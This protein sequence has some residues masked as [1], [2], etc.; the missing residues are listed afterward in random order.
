M[1]VFR[2]LLGSRQDP[3]PVLVAAGARP[4]WMSD[5]MAVRISEG[6]ENLEVVGESFYQEALWR[7][8]GGGSPHEPVRIEV[9]AVLVAET[10]NP[11]DANA[12]SIW[13]GGLKVGHL[14]RNEAERLRPGL[15][16]LEQQHGMPSALRGVIVGG[17][18]K[19]DGPG[20]LGVFLRYDPEDFGLQASKPAPTPGARMDTGFSEALA[21]DE[22]DDAYD[23]HWMNELPEDPIRAITAL[24]KLLEGE[25]DPVDRHFM[26]HQLEVALYKSREAF[27]SALDEF[28]E[29][30]RLHDADMEAICEAFVSKSGSIPWLHTYKQ[31]CIRLAKAKDFEAAL[32]W[33][34]RGLSLYGER[35]GREDAVADLQSRANTYRGRLGRG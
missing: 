8:A 22:A 29:C 33:A 13:V 32:W 26:F 34:D 18:L 12:V 3:P 16:A 5:G 10:D 21:T 31:M 35:A 1:G 6:R 4:S 20:R 19:A 23:L 25:R 11:H 2:R 30:C 15:L 14:S 17:G 7:L 24:R 28:D 9:M 27:A